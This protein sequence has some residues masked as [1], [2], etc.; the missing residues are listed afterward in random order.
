[1]RIFQ[2]FLSNNSIILLSILFFFFFYLEQFLT[3]S[4]P[5]TREHNKR[6]QFLFLQKNTFESILP[7]NKAFSNPSPRFYMGHPVYEREREWILS[8]DGAW[9]CNRQDFSPG[10]CRE[11][12]VCWK[13]I[14][15]WRRSFRPLEE[16][17][18]RR[19]RLEGNRRVFLQ[20]LPPL[21]R[22]SLFDSELCIARSVMF[23]LAE[24][25]TYKVVVVRCS[26]LVCAVELK[27]LLPSLFSRLYANCKL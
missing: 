21:A 13:N 24:I 7:R 10:L 20:P 16:T 2:L 9:P 25:E 18:K 22:P 27:F 15:R 23:V 19:Y 26:P 4:Y 6:G 12:F 3:K 17:W 5:I 8:M 11:R 14:D 1:M